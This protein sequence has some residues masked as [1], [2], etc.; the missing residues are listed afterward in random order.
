MINS[1]RGR[2][3]QTRSQKKKEPTVRVL[4]REAGREH[5]RGSDDRGVEKGKRKRRDNRYREDRK[6]R[7]DRNITNG[8]GQKD[9]CTYRK[10]PY[11]IKNHMERE[12]RKEKP[13]D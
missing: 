13:R 6:N 8:P 11:A 5:R 10:S 4:M 2:V 9:R 7:I 1:R 12:R 3:Q